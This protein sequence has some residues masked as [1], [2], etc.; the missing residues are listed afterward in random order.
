MP[1]RPLPPKTSI[2]SADDLLSRL[3]KGAMAIGGAATAR[4]TV[5][6]DAE[7]DPDGN[8]LLPP[9]KSRCG[10]TVELQRGALS[11]SLD[12]LPRVTVGQG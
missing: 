7:V 10:F 9:V 11:V 6:L 8:G 12:T 1:P 4:I 5:T 2:P 3:L